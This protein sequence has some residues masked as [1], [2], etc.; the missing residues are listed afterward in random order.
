MHTRAIELYVVEFQ[1]VI[2]GASRRHVFTYDDLKREF[3]TLK[4]GA[5]MFSWSPLFDALEA[6]ERR[7]QTDDLTQIKHRSFMANEMVRLSLL[8]ESCLKEADQTPLEGHTQDEVL[9]SGIVEPLLILANQTGK[10]LNDIEIEGDLEGFASGP[11]GSLLVVLSHMLR[12]AV[13]HGIETPKARRELG[14]SEGGSICIRFMDLKN[15][16]PPQY[17]IEVSDDGMGINVE[18]LRAK[19]KSKGMKNVDQ[20]SDDDVI[21]AIFGHGIST[22]TNITEIS[23]RGVGLNAVST[24]VAKFGGTVRVSSRKNQ[25]TKMSI[26]IPQIAVVRKAS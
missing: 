6:F 11:Y 9:R 14:K 21:Q 3:H 22:K 2:E 20:H 19:L 16:I 4:S 8:L 18:A 7:L 1:R 23:G 24:E 13:D 12:N 15:S 17:V 5:A 10:F 25:G 26:R